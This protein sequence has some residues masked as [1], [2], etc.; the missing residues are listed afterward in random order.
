[1]D[2]IRIHQTRRQEGRKEKMIDLSKIT[3]TNGGKQ[4]K[5]LH[6]SEGFIFGMVESRYPEHFYPGQW[7]L[8]GSFGIDGLKSSLSLNTGLD[9][10][11]EDDSNRFIVQGR[12]YPK[13]QAELFEESYWKNHPRRS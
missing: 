12:R 8:D 1:M 2:S 11:N 6:F 7:N 10:E 13:S 4:V 9:N 5:D 3:H